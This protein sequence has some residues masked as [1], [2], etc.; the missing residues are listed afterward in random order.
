[1]QVEVTNMTE[2]RRDDKISF[3]QLQGKNLSKMGQK[4]LNVTNLIS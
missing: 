2:K 4:Q 3:N 1:M